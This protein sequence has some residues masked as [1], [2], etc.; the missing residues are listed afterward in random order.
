MVFY[1]K[2]LCFV[3]LEI[4]H[5]RLYIKFW[6][7]FKCLSSMRWS[8]TP[9]AIKQTIKNCNNLPSCKFWVG[10]KTCARINK[11]EKTTIFEGSLWSVSWREIYRLSRGSGFFTWWYCL[12]SIFWVLHTKSKKLK[13][14]IVGIWAHPL[15][16]KAS[17][18]LAHSKHL[19]VPV[20]GREDLEKRLLLY[21]GREVWKR[22]DLNVCETIVFPVRDRFAK[23]RKRFVFSGEGE[24]VWW[25]N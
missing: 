5:M 21:R 18:Q 15:K 6:E 14:V 25:L 23:V 22:V 12:V 24:K 11:K 1:W 20:H 17:G 16:N 13:H 2:M 7:H 3:P 9:L 4:T 19:D 8:C 10:T